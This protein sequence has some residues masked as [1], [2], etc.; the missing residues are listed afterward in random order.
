MTSK[1]ALGMLLAVS[2]AALA[3]VQVSGQT[4][5]D[6]ASPPQADLNL[7]G[8]LTVFGKPDPNR[9]TATAIING[10]IITGTDVEQRLALIAIAN[11][12]RI[13]ENERDRLRAQVLRNLIDESLQIQ[14][15]VAN[16]ITIEPAEIE[17]RYAVL[18][19]NFRRTPQQMSEYL[20]GEGSSDRS[21]KRQIHAEIAWQRLLQRRVQPFVNV[22]EEEVRSIMQRLEASKGQIEYHVGEIYLSSA[23]E[24]AP[25]TIENA[26]RI[27]EQIRQGGSFAAYARQ[28]SEASTAALGG[29]LGWIRP[30]QLPP[31]LAEAAQQMQVGQ[32]AGPIEVP[33]GFS[34]LYL[35]D[36]RQVLT[37]DPR[38][39][40]LSLRQIAISFPAG[41]TRA[42]AGPRVE[43]FAKA[44]QTIAGCG[45][46][47]PVATQLGAEV[48]NN[49]AVRIRDLPPPLQDILLNLQVG[50]A[51]QPFG[52]L[53]DGVRVLV[54]CGR[55]E[56]QGA[57]S[58]SFDTIMAQMEEEKINLRARRYLRDLRRDAVVDY[59]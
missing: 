19:R 35:I 25:Q 27:M 43:A 24:N 30:A 55:D 39:A 5:E 6:G 56:P 14:E 57:G 48:V 1:T 38:D 15:A 20:A 40:V 16:E 41:M 2:A 33:G 59:R 11:G 32:L 18:S 53:E 7:P 12:G 8:N 9:R 54:L 45:S 26:R 44:T 51:T 29:D 28:F 58:P 49:D 34:I 52:S 42:D 4:V 50:Q 23:P 3:S 13:P 31:S 37:A 36:Q 21:I 46:V 10:D 47:Q 17:E 22:A